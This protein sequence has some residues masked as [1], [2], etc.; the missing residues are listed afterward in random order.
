VMIGK[1]SDFSSK[2]GQASVFML[3]VLSFACCTGY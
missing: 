3:T 1:S 2:G